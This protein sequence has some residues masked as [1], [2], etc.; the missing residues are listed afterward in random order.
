M[1]IKTYLALSENY[2]KL[3]GAQKSAYKTGKKLAKLEKRGDISLLEKF[4]NLFRKAENKVTYENTKK[5][6][7][8]S[9]KESADN[10]KDINKT[11]KAGR[12]IVESGATAGFKNT[13]KGLFKKEIKSKFNLGI[14]VLTTFIPAM[15]QKAIPAFKEKGFFAG[16]KETGKA[17]VQTA[18]DFISYGFGGAIGRAG[19]YALVLD[20]LAGREGMS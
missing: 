5:V 17:V 19:G 2:E 12:E 3:R 1:F 11:L 6:L 13:A 10:L 15:M 7:S 20:R 16:L 18:T 14:S 9:A 4:K 8:S